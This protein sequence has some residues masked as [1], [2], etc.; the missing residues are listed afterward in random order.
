LQKFVKGGDNNNH[1]IEVCPC[2]H[3]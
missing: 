2:P 3:H 1:G